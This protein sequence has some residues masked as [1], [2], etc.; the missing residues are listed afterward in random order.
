MRPTVARVIN[1]DTYK[2]GIVTY[3]NNGSVVFGNGES[4]TTLWLRK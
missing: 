3:H 1:E 4:Y 2:F